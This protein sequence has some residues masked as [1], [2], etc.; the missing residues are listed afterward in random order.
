MA[1][2]TEWTD[3]FEHQAEWGV[4]RG[5]WVSNSLYLLVA[6]YLGG[7]GAGAA[8]ISLYLGRENSDWYFVAG[9]VI[10]F[11]GKGF[12]HMLFLGNPRRFWRAALRPQ[13]SWISRGVIALGLFG[14]TG[15]LYILWPVF[16]VFGGAGDA[17][18][19]LAIINATLLGILILYDGFLLNA[20][21]G[22]GAWNTSLMLVLFPVFNLLGGVGLV[23]ALYGPIH[24]DVPLDIGYLHEIETVL[25]VVGAIVLGG[26]L[27][28][29]YNNPLS[30]L[31]ELEAVVG[32]KR[33]VFWIAVV[34]GG[35]VAPLIVT[36][37]SL[38]TD[39]A[40][41][42]MAAAALAAVL[43]D[44]AFKYVVLSIGEHP[45]VYTPSRATWLG[46]SRQKL[47]QS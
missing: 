13:S 7:I 1:Q 45:P 37:L 40:V 41:G 30:R 5:G 25:L 34:G 2:V 38:S 4:G 47:S 20:A 15:L 11:V 10:G 44:Y 6:L 12:F 9:Y 24:K 19:P 39:A 32:R 35:I 31:S 29:L 26:Y 23:G 3:G 17:E 21:T 16:E 36:A 28:T 33:Y 46:G 27:L 14:V 42:I 22:I 8:L 18:L 43:S